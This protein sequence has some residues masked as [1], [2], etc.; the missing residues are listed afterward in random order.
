MVFI[1]NGVQSGENS[2]LLQ[3]ALL[4]EENES[5]RTSV[6]THF[7]DEQANKLLTK[8]NS[9]NDPKP[10]EANNALNHQLAKSGKLKLS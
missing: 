7:R 2:I 4:K 1:V 6:R 8:K 3:L 9:K 10:H 5:L